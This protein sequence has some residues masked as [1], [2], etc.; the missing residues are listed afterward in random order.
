MRKIIKGKRYDT[1]KAECVASAS[2]GYKSD[3]HYWAEDLYR[4]PRGNWFLVG[5]GNALSRYSVPGAQHGSTA[6][7]EKLIPMTND[8]AK[9]WLEEQG[10]TAM[11]E[12]H[13]AESIEDA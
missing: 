13:F 5:E 2:H 12:E 4:T 3:F 7:G 10:E 6:P 9:Q 1:E 8:D 11:L